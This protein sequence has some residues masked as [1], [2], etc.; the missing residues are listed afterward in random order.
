[1]TRREVQAGDRNIG[2][3]RISILLKAMRLEVI[4]KVNIDEKIRGLSLGTFSRSRGQGHEEEP[5][6]I[7]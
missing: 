3:I 1:M 2:A 5:A 4:R 6:K 7:E